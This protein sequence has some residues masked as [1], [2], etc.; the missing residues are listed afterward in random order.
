MTSSQRGHLKN[1]V[2]PSP[3]SFS[4]GRRFL[5]SP[6]STY[7]VRAVILSL[8]ISLFL[9]CFQ[10][11][12]KICLVLVAKRALSDLVMALACTWFWTTRTCR[13]AGGGFNY[14]WGSSCGRC[15]SRHSRRRTCGWGCTS[16]C[17][18]W[19]MNLFTYVLFVTFAALYPIA[20]IWYS[21]DKAMW[22]GE[23][24]CG[25]STGLSSIRC[26]EY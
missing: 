20:A 8:E 6:L 22:L 14:H 23:F 26:S 9:T 16:G 13:C 2:F 11:L 25:N 4:T 17:R 3:L 19:C 21:E 24:P 12:Q 1:G 18:G 10:V 15:G 5:W 7:W